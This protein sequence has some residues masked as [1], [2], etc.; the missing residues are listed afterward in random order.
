M[1]GLHLKGA[2]YVALEG[3]GLLQA[4]QEEGGGSGSS[5]KVPGRLKCLEPY[6]SFPFPFSLGTLRGWGLV[7]KGV[8]PPSF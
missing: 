3:P 1:S 8:Q 2:S 7:W 5:P 4:P 6:R